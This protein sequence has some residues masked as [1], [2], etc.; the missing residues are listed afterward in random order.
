VFQ[1]S[2]KY[3]QFGLKFNARYLEIPSTRKSSV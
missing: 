3:L 2:K 1:L